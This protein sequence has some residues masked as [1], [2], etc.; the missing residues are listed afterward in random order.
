MIAVAGVVR[1]PPEIDAEVEGFLNFALPNEIRPSLVG[2]TGVAVEKRL[3]A[4]IK[5]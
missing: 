5:K 4:V 2:N 1:R 3:H